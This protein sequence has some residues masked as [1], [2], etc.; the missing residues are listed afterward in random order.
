MGLYTKF[1]LILGLGIISFLMNSNSFAGCG[2]STHKQDSDS[3][4]HSYPPTELYYLLAEPAYAGNIAR[5]LHK[6]T[7]NSYNPITKTTLLEQAITTIEDSV[8]CSKVIRILVLN[9]AKVNHRNYQKKTPLM[10]A[11]DKGSPSTVNLLLL[12]GA[13]RADLYNNMSL[14]EYILSKMRFYEA[15]PHNTHNQEKLINLRS[16]LRNV[17]GIDT[18]SKQK[19][20]K[21]SSSLIRQLFTYPVDAIVND[22]NVI[23]QGYM[24]D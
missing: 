3:F 19:K 13:R 7:I 11:I 12:L 21:K 2:A 8:V 20:H 6:D 16:I 14:E 4:E 17:A 9:G 5:F 24:T 23:D 18:Y 22:K 10:Q 1:Y 15:L